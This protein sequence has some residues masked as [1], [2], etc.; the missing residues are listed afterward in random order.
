MHITSRHDHLLMVGKSVSRYTR[1][2][3]KAL[4]SL[5]LWHNQWEGRKINRH[6]AEKIAAI[7]DAIYMRTKLGFVASHRRGGG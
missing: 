5:S 3:P 7:R 4:G 6:D 1:R 2:R